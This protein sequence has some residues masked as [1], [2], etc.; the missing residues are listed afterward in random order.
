MASTDSKF[1]VN[2]IWCYKRKGDGLWEVTWRTNQPKYGI[3]VLYRR[4]DIF[5]EA[6]SFAATIKDPA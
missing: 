2:S 5:S 1:R 4:F 6:I 3:Q